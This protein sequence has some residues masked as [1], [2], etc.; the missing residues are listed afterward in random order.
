MRFFFSACDIVALT[1]ETKKP[2]AIIVVEVKLTKDVKAH[3]ELVVNHDNSF[4]VIE[5]T[6]K[7]ITGNHCYN[8]SPFIV[9]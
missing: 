4:G 2:E 8:L 6:I 9:S 5:K 3:D 1:D 7:V